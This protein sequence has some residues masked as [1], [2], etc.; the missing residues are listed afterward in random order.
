MRKIAIS[1]V[2]ALTAWG[3]WATWMSVGEEVSQWRWEWG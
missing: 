3:V 1:A 2:A